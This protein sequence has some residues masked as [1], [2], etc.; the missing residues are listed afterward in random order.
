MIKKTK[1]QKQAEYRL[2]KRNEL[3][4]VEYKKL[5]A[6]RQRNKY[7]ANKPQIIIEKLDE[8]IE[9]DKLQPLKKRINPISKILLTENSIKTYI[10]TIKIIYNFY[11]KKILSDDNEIIKTIISKPYKYKIIK[12]DFIFLFDND[13]LNNIIKNYKSRLDILYGII[14]RI[15][16]FSSIVKKLTPYV[17]KINDINKINRSNR[18]IPENIINNV[19]FD[20]IHIIKKVEEANLTNYEKI[21]AYITLLIPTRRLHDYRFTKNINKIPNNNI[22][23]LFNYYYNK[24]IYIYNTKNKKFDIINIPDE[25]NNLINIYDEFIFGKFY[26]QSALSKIFSTIM[27]KIYNIKINATLIRILYATYLRSL[28]LSAKDWEEKA[29]KMGHSL[30]ENIKYSYIQKKK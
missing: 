1:A 18:I 19:S 22:N 29:Q 20:K 25:I 16:G 24:N 28:N 30:G 23:K 13:I 26:N 9:I 8:N 12:N 21:I 5:E 15:Y 10:S 2:K 4:E 17:I 3:G 6:E 7:N 27:F 11:T 14:S